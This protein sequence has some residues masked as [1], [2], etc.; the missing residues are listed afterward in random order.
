MGNRHLPQLVP[1]PADLP[2]QVARALA[3]DVGAGDLTAALVPLE[4]FGRASVITR[5]AAVVCG[6]PYAEA[7]FHQ[8]DARVRI[9]SRV[10]EGDSVRAN[11]LLLTVEGPARALLTGERTALNFLQLLSATAT[12][13][14]AYASLLEGT[15]CR[16]LDTRKTIPGLRSAQKYA[17][18][19]GGGHN[20]RMGLFD[21][22]LIKENHIMAAGSIAAAVTAARVG[23]G[24]VA[25]VVEVENMA[26]LRQ[27]I[28]AGADIAMLDEFS[29]EDMREAVALKTQAAAALAKRP[30]KLEAS[31]GITAAT[32]R[33]IAETGVDFI[34]VGS[35]TKHVRAVDLSMRFEWKT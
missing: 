19:V 9:E 13:A 11:Q 10:A 7:S 31:G 5:E 4:R 22:I 25:V 33:E 2:Q 8:I 35:I 32:I 15:N 29:L 27:A 26:E 17:V 34:S 12:A 30:L 16:L 3:E 6:M 20:H 24:Q 28:D 21:G 1:V 14:H 23:G 18:R